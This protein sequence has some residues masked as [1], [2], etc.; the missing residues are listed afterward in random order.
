MIGGGAGGAVGPAAW[1]GG[2]S[3]A[4]GRAAAGPG[5]ARAAQPGG[6]APYAGFQSNVTVAFEGIV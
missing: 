5:R 6:P 4:P 3:G 1:R 2:A